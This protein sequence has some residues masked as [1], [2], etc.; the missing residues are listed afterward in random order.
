MK[1]YTWTNSSSFGFRVMEEGE[2]LED[3]W[4]GF[5]ACCCCELLGPLL[6]PLVIFLVF[7]L[8]PSVASCLAGLH[9][10]KCCD[11]CYLEELPVHLRMET[12]LCSAVLVVIAVK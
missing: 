5:T 6:F 10:F 12:G 3:E 9:T 11:L 7:F 2:L 1:N 4:E 8:I